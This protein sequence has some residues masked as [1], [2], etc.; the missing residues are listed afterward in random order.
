M[1]EKKFINLVDRL[2]DGYRLGCEMRGCV[3]AHRNSFAAGVFGVV[4]LLLDSS[5]KVTVEQA[6]NVI[7]EDVRAYEDERGHFAGVCDGDK[8]D[9]GAN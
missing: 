7:R 3:H 4:H 6:L 8:P 9:V 5:Q 2:F 1:H